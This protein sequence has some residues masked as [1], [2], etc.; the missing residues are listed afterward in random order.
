MRIREV[1]LSAALLGLTAAC[2]VTATAPR[3]VVHT[4]GV[5]V[6]EVVVAR[7]PPPVQVEEVPPPP[8]HPELW[9]WHAGHW[10]WEHND[11]VWHP[12]HYERRP[13]DTAVWVQPEWV[14]RGGQWVFHPGHWDYR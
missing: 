11:Y 2:T 5:V 10:R 4:P 7:P 14:A 12:G 3:V 1:F 13:S 9:V 8:R 6:G